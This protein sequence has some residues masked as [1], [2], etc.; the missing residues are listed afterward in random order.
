MATAIK[1]RDSGHGDLLKAMLLAYPVFDT[2]VSEAADRRY[3]GEV[4]MLSGAEMAGFWRNYLSSPA[5]RAKRP[6]PPPCWP[7]SRACRPP[8]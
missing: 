6:R 2:E 4:Y 8:A 1:L 5:G 7:M 3:G